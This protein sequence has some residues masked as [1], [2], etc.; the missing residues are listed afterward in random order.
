MTRRFLTGQPAG[1]VILEGVLAALV[2][3]LALAP[4]PLPPQPKGRTERRDPLEQAD[5]L[6]RAYQQVD[7]TRTATQRLLRGVRSRTARGAPRG[8]ADAD[9]A[10]VEQVATSAPERAADV[11]LVLRG[12]GAQGAAPALADIGAALRRIEDAL[13]ITTGRA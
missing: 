13:T 9:R 6:A 12:L 1:R 8:G 10:F 3:L 4:R 2:L 11:A 5:A 7:A